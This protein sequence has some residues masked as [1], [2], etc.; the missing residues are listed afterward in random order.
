MAAL[1]SAIAAALRSVRVRSNAA[2][3][4]LH[5]SIG[6]SGLC[7]AAISLS[8][9][10]VAHAQERRAAGLDS[11]EEVVITGTRIRQREDYVSPNPV[12]TFGAEELQNLGLVNIADAVAQI[13]SNVST[14]QA[15][16]TGGS[17]FF[18]GSTLAN[19]RG[20][21]PFFGTRTLTLVDSRRFVPTNQGGSVDLNFVPSLLIE[22]M[23]IVT[24][25]ASAAY[26]SEAI[27]GVVNILLDHNLDGIKME[28]DYGASTEGDGDNYHFGFGAGTPFGARGH[29]MIGGE[30]QKQEGI[31]DCYTA[32]GWC[33]E[34]I[35]NFSNGSGGGAFDPNP[36]PHPYVATI[37]GQP[38]NIIRSNMRV[39][40]ASYTG[41]I[42]NNTPGATTALQSN[43]A[44]TG[45]VPFTIGQYG[46]A[47]PAGLT[48]NVS[49]GDGRS[50]YSGVALMPETERTTSYA[51]LS[52]DF[53]DT[54]NGF[55]E[56]SYGEVEA[57]NEQTGAGQNLANMCIRSDNAYVVLNGMQGPIAA[58]AGNGNA[59]FTCFDPFLPPRTVVSKD[60]TNLTD[61]RVATDTE[62]FRAVIGLH[63]DL[64]QTWSW[65]TYYTFGR[66]KRDQIGH[67]YRTN[68]RFSM[69]VDSV[70]NPATG[71]PVCRVTLNPA[72][73][74]FG[75][76]PSLA[77]GCQPL[78]PFGANTQ[79]AA[80]KAYAWG[81]L[82]ESNTIEQQVIAGNLTGELWS[83]IGAGAFAAA[84]GAEYRQEELENLA[85]DLPFAQRTDFGLQYGDPFGGTVDVIEGFVE[86][87]MPLLR[88]KPGA[89]IVS[90]NVAARQAHYKNEGGLGTTGLTASNDI[91][92]WKAAAVWDPIEWLRLRGSLS[93]DIRAAGFRELYYSQTI[94]SGGLFGA[95][96][97]FWLPDL[98]PNTQ[99]DETIIILS[100]EPRLE[101]EEADTFTAGFVVSPGGW[102]DGM[103]LSLDYYR[104][105]M[106]NGIALGVAPD[107]VRQCFNG[108]QR[109][110]EYI[111]FGTPTNPAIP[112]S[113]IVQL[114]SPYINARPYESSGMDLAADYALPLNRFS[115]G[116]AGALSFRLTATYTFETIVQ[117]TGR[118]IRDIAGQTGGDQGFLSDFASA[119]DWSANLVVTYSNGPFML[120][121]QGRFISDGVLDRQTPKRGPDDP[122]FSPQLT[123]SVSDNTVPSFFTLNLSGSYDFAFGALEKTQLFATVD[124]VF[125]RDPP[126]SAGLV[127]GVNG[128]FFETMGRTYRVGMRLQ[129]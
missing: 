22:R 80:A 13:P 50:V 3:W 4:N 11:L 57:V 107:V 70:I 20:L 120:T 123:N 19:L 88:D 53:T 25:G 14:F 94:P 92:T 119:P 125:D 66:T 71:Q 96:T 43:A 82:T 101:P 77:N 78:N 8:L 9:S 126:Y 32:R 76:D 116:A 59:S 35:A 49:G 72:A 44:G 46:H 28:M 34:G 105:K 67:D 129:F 38:Q 117:A 69:A 6:R 84:V 115:D 113:N 12:A 124:N 18:V 30:Y 33:A 47:G 121:T 2:D 81:N 41:V 36:L 118:I 79:S 60:F 40:Q 26:G 10:G 24:G 58:A 48:T 45:F 7:A 68:H 5:S 21:N 128:V 104:I 100:G 93:R 42:F 16:N 55:V 99:R 23:E 1:H 51:R 27:S 37:P 89:R 111:T 127:G 29:F 122:N 86:L 17:A 91:T 74:P 64:S 112:Q 39:N 83:G 103:H 65:D 106:T 52:Y 54:L 31:L 73:L 15:G 85:G 95:T 114:R 75:A 56:A 110:C 87:E 108:D 62:V 90:L 61:Q 97:N 102:A 98:G 63:G 109:Q